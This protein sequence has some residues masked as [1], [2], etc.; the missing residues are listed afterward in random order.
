[1]M[2]YSHTFHIRVFYTQLAY[3]LLFMFELFNDDIIITNTLSK[4]FENEGVGLVNNGGIEAGKVDL[5]S[6]LAV[7]THSFG[8]YR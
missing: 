8:Y 7:M 6:C 1:M 2:F 5:G 4:R 3:I